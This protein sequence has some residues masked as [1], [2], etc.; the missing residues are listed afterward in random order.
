[1]LENELKCLE[2]LMHSITKDSNLATEVS[3]KFETPETFN[4]HKTNLFNQISIN[5]LLT[6]F[7]ENPTFSLE[8]FLNNGII[9]NLYP[10][11]TS[12]PSVVPKYFINTPSFYADLIQALKDGN[13]VFDSE[14]NIYI[15]SSNLEATIPVLWLYRLSQACKKDKYEKVYFFNKNKKTH[16][17]DK[18][19]LID[20]LR[21]TKTFVVELSSAYP[22]ID[23]EIVFS[24]IKS[25]IN[26]KFKNKREVKVDDLIDQFYEYLPTGYEARISKYR[27]KDEYWLIKKAQTMGEA[28]YN[29]PLNIQEKYL[30]KWII[31]H[32][33]SLF[34]SASETQKFILLSYTPELNEYDLDKESIIIGLFNLYISILKS[35]EIDY[36]EI[37]LSSFKIKN[38]I[39]EQ[40]QK[41][42]I[43]RRQID[44]EINANNNELNAANNK[45]FE[46]LQEIDDIDIIKDFPI[47]NSKQSE[48]ERLI[49]SIILMKEKNR[50]LTD[51]KKSLSN[52]EDLAFDNDLIMELL[53]KAT[54][55]GNI[56]ILDNNLIIELYNPQI[57]EPVFK[58]VITIN[59][60]NEFISRTNTLLTSVGTPTMR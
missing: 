5:T 39:D 49:K 58:V 23:Y 19:S 6:Y 35:L 27:L 7:T 46:L 29:E 21:M 55:E 30:N 37:S 50:E 4:Q 32:K 25:R 47:I 43:N 3:E 57:S 28:F 59:K 26:E 11:P 56:Y 16:I 8:Y 40:S 20:Y 48:Y 45:L 38:Y 24:S 60:L 42:M 51:N 34:V 17:K 14:N 10:E 15:S 54:N 33:N 13:Y 44:R 2:I 36:S 41:N 12:V 22:K 9:P 1:M 52:I 18:Q 31:E 53:A